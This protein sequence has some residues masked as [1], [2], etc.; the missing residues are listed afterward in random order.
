MCALPGYDRA[1]RPNGRAFLATAGD[2]QSVAVWDPATLSQV[3]EP[4]LGHSDTIQDICAFAMPDPEG[5]DRI[6]LA[7]AGFDGTIRLW[8]PAAGQPHGNPLTG[9]SA[10]V[11][12]VIPLPGLEAA[13]PIRL[14]STGYDRTVRVW[15]PRIG[16]QVVE[17]FTGH[18]GRVWGACTLPGVNPSGQPGRY[19]LIASTGDDG[20]VRIWDP[21]TGRT[22]GEPLT[23]FPTR[24]TRSSG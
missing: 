19:P 21:N 13:T 14:I 17:S 2:D 15:D 11:L 3:S 22:V 20:T 16:K 5:G 4:L 18:D 24:S 23:E 9:H 1:G 12:G 8:D 7:T 6:L 10:S